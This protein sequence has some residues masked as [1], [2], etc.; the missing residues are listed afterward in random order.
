MNY[1]ENQEIAWLLREKYLGVKSAAFEADCARLA[2]GEPLG[3]LIGHVP[4]LDCTIH[5]DSHPLIPRVETEYWVEKAIGAVSKLRGRTPKILDL[6]AGSGAIGVAVAKAVPDAN[7]TFAEIDPAHLP[8]I[9]KNIETNTPLWFNRLNYYKVVAGDLFESVDGLFDYILTNPPYINAEAN[10]VDENVATYEPHLA[11]FG[12]AAGMEIIAR[13]I[14]EA[15]THLTPTGQLWIEHEPVQV[16]AIT[17]LAHTHG[18]FIV[19]HPDQYDTPRY[20]I[21]SMAQL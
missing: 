13:I 5:L 20:S 18:F 14:A 2:A 8:T 16:E 4:F 9:Q 10:T 6:C 1:M 19:T 21:L 12:G 15:P 17:A 3:Y 7:L 11:L